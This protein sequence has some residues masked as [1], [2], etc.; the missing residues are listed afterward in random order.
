MSKNFTFFWFCVIQF[1]NEYKTTI[2][3][4]YNLKTNTAEEKEIKNLD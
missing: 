3:I 1:S 2:K 4:I